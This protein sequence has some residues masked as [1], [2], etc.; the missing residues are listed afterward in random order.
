M[1]LDKVCVDSAKC[2]G[3]ED[4]VGVVVTAPVKVIA[5][6]SGML[7]VEETIVLLVELAVVLVAPPS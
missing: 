1:V 7:T 4:N 3:V 5:G 2:E 6:P